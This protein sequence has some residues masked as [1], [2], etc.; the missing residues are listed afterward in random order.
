MAT[1]RPTT[2]Q[3]SDIIGWFK[4]RELVINPDFQRHSVWTAKARTFLIDTILNELPMPKI[5]L[6]TKVDPKTQESI[7]EVVDGQQR[8]RAIVDFAEGKLQLGDRSDNFK[9]KVYETL[10]DADKD[11]FL[12]YLV[13][14][15]QFLNATDDDVIDIFARLNSYTVALNAAELRHADFQTEFKFTVRKSAQE[16]RAFI[17]K[18]GIFTMKQRFRMSDDALF[19]ELYG[20]IL[21]GVT[22]GGEPKIRKLYER[23]DDVRFSAEVK[24][25]A[26][27]KLDEALRFLDVSLGDAMNGGFAKHYHVL[28]MVAAY[29]HHRYGIP[30][31]N[32]DSMP[33]RSELASIE[34]ILER[35]NDIERALEKG[36]PL[37]P[38]KDFV[39]A[40]SSS[41]HRIT[42]RKTRFLEFARIF[43]R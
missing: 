9:G 39:A 6:R 1:A 7:R 18:Y 32:L 27:A 25:Q 21:D 14:A 26:K 28:M 40:C 3:V 24:A 42:S 22:D 17:E 31:G 5:Y 33:A 16:W 35:L 2:F 38:H 20:V 41:T 30:K 13:T 43:G 4:R 12:A 8:I 11:R 37:G 36:S 15:E 34:E 19:A 29:L 10:D 23:Q